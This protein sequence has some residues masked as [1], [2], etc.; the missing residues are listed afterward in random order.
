[1]SSPIVHQQDGVVPMD[2]PMALR[3]VMIGKKITKLEWGNPKIY[4]R[5]KDGFLTIRK[6][7]GRFHSLLISDGDIFGEDWVVVPDDN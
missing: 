3:Q 7:D 1:M 4:V 6:E 5:M 2:F